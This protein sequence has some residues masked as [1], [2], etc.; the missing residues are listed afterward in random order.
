[1]LAALSQAIGIPS[2]LGFADIVNHQL[3]ENIIKF[4][5]T[6][7]LRYHGFCELYIGER[8]VKATPSF[9]LAICQEK[10]IIPVEFDGMTDALLLSHDI[11]GEQHIDNVSYNGNF[12]D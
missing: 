5:G 4:Q 2:R 1:M 10:G 12:E 11:D 3:P 9:D 7:L 8:W 6:N